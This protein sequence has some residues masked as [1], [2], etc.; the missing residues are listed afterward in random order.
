MVTHGIFSDTEMVDKGFSTCK[1]KGLYFF[2]VYTDTPLSTE[3]S[4]QPIIIAHKD[5]TTATTHYYKGFYFDFPLSDLP[6]YKYG[7]LNYC[8]KFAGESFTE[9]ICVPRHKDLLLVAHKMSGK[10]TDSEIK[11]LRA[12]AWRR[13]IDDCTMTIHSNGSFGSSQLLLFDS[14]VIKEL[15]IYQRCRYHLRKLCR[16]I[17]RKVGLTPV[18]IIIK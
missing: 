16:A 11:E 17:L 1:P 10:F 8:E 15:S 5:I 13:C 9:L 6:G 2:W 4:W 12:K 18:I 14:Y 3:Y 7:L